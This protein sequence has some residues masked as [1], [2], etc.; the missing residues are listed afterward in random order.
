M[1]L[2]LFRA[3]AFASFITYASTIY[4]SRAQKCVCGDIPTC[5]CSCLHTHFLHAHK[6]THKRTQSARLF[7]FASP[8]RSECIQFARCVCCRAFFPPRLSLYHLR[9]NAYIVRV[10]VRRRSTM[11]FSHSEQHKICVCVCVMN[12]LSQPLP[13]KT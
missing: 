12:T 3:F 11:A 5:A 8:C 2:I 7:G 10:R 1:I 6:Y 4:A 9:T 13:R